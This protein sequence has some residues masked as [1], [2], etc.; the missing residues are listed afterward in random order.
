MVSAAANMPNNTHQPLFHPF[1]PL[2]SPPRSKPKL[3]SLDHIDAH[4]LNTRLNLLLDKPGRHHVDGPHA[5]RVLRR[6][7]CRGR[8]GVAA[9]GG[10]DFLVCFEAA[11]MC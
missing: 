9:M 11:V 6:Q 3:T 8:H 4:V 10:H 2:A 7:R 5:L 1:Y